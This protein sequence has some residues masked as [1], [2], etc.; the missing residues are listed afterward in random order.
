MS[1]GWNLENL[2]VRYSVESQW[3]AQNAESDIRPAETP[4]RARPG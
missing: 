3:V 1:Q 2:H 4:E